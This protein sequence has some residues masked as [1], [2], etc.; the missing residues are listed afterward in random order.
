M[1][2][3]NSTFS[4][5]FPKSRAPKNENFVPAKFWLNI[6]YEVEYPVDGDTTEMRF[7]SLPMGIGLDTQEKVAT[8][9]QSEVYAAFQTARNELHEQ[10]MAVAN[11]LKPGEAKIVSRDP[12]TGLCTQ[13]RRVNDEKPAIKSDVNPFTKSLALAA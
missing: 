3:T 10:L 6:G 1:S 11:T 4:A 8:N 2:I 7:L 5:N 12:V 13:L 9:S